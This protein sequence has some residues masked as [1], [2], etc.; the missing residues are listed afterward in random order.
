MTDQTL[1]QTLKLLARIIEQ[2]DAAE[3]VQFVNDILPVHFEH[4]P[5]LKEVTEAIKIG[6][7]ARRA[8]TATTVTGKHA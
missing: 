2:P 4:R 6:H 8:I 7:S 1:P 3:W 5:S